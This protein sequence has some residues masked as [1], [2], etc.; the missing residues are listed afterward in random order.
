[1]EY[2]IN[3]EPEAMDWS[4]VAEIFQQVGW[5]VRDPEDIRRAFAQSSLVCVAQDNQGRIVGFGRTVDDGRYY[6][7]LVD[8]VV[9]PDAQS[10]GIGSRMVRMLQECLVGYNFITL[11]A[12]PGKESFY[13]K[14]GWEKQTSSYIFPKDEK[15]RREHCA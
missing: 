11:T 10:S 12:A 15:Q 1:M 7:L 6:A 9:R 14:L 2:Q 8:V 3:P 13:Q 5:G 4:A